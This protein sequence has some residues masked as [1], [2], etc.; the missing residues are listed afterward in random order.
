[1]VDFS[2]SSGAKMAT[3]S[4]T[5]EFKRDCVACGRSVVCAV[6]NSDRKM[7]SFGGLVS[8]KPS[9]ILV[10]TIRSFCDRR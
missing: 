3:M 7:D 10:K 8:R 6:A 2:G 4:P 1:M 5:T 9:N